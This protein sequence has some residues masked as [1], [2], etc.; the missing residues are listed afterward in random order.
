MRR[1]RRTEQH[2]GS[3]SS[4]DGCSCRHCRR[5]FSS[6]MSHLRRYLYPYTTLSAQNLQINEPRERE[7]FSNES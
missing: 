2:R 7:H 1:H 3:S 6:P 5:A 4:L